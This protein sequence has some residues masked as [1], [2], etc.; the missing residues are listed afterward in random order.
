MLK[1]MVLLVSITALLLH[2]VAY[3]QDKDDTLNIRQTVTPIL[4]GALIDDD[5]LRLRDDYL[6]KDSM[7]IA[8]VDSFMAD[9][10]FLESYGE[11]IYNR[12]S[13]DPMFA[14]LVIMGGEMLTPVS[15]GFIPKIEF[16][17][18]LRP[19]DA[20]GLGLRKFLK[21]DAGLDKLS[22]ELKSA[23]DIFLFAVVNADRDLDESYA[24]TPRDSM[25]YGL[26]SLLMDDELNEKKSVEEL[27]SLGEIGEEWAKRMA[28]L[29]PRYK[30]GMML[31]GGRTLAGW[32][33]NVI[34]RGKDSYFGEVQLASKIEFETDWGKIGVGTENDD[35]YSG[36]YVL[37]IDPGGDDSYN[38]K[39]VYGHTVT[40]VVDYNGD[41]IYKFTNDSLYSY[42]ETEKILNDKPPG[43]GGY[44]YLV[45]YNGDDIYKGH[46]FSLAAGIY[47]VSIFKDYDGDDTY[48]T[49]TFGPAAGS[50]GIG[51]LMDFRGRDRYD[52][53]IYNEGYAF[54]GGLGILFDAGGHDSYL[55]GGKYGDI[56]RYEDH[57]VTFAQGSAFGLRPYL[58]GG[59]GM[60]LDGSGNDIYFSDIFG[61]ASGYW[62]SAGIIYDKTGNDRYQSFQYAQGAGTH[63]AVGCLRDVAG[64]D[65]YF[66][67]GV[68]QGCGH[69]YAHGW[70]V[71]Y[72]GDDVY[73]A[74]DLSQGAGS[75][76]GIGAIVD[77]D[78]SDR[79][80]VKS[81]RNTQGYGNPRRDYGSI[82]LFYDGG[83]F[84]R[85]DGGPGSDNNIWI[86]SRWGI[87][88]DEFTEDTT[89][90]R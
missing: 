54:T 87:G 78:G 33:D 73:S 47:G 22:D 49:D 86:Y 74:Y 70:L 77:L 56:L 30:L 44:T 76:N 46:D 21:S 34:G 66:S 38:I 79:Y 61:Q 2:P 84:D 43:I 7:R 60:L 31:N 12:M 59:I 68:S 58:S 67:K 4:K 13:E 85:Y 25:I 51:I 6:E 17:S 20:P 1:R 39:A 42:T 15:E 81:D 35:I 29:L 64:D 19:H 57:Y 82:G 5:D 32:L 40:V 23:I 53:A 9:P 63:M 14:E 52:G 18:I 83:G 36:S 75:A 62:Y 80:Y 65:V 37:I 50:M 26:A 48:N 69:D 27:D 8:L 88:W 45:D 55:S 72:S 71:D 24:E 10:Y 90:T 41:D 11:V 16:K 28:E 3:A 89:G